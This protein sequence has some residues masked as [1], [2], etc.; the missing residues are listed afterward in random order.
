MGLGWDVHMK[1]VETGER[2]PSFHIFP[3]LFDRG[4][5]RQKLKRV[6][7]TYG[8]P[9]VYE[10]TAREVNTSLWEHKMSS[11]TGSCG[12]PKMPEVLAWLSDVSR[13][14]TAAI[15]RLELWDQS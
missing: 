15:V 14:D 4:N 3:H 7:F 5:E 9:D 6:S 13:A 1:V 8:F 11:F 10:G 12:L 2:G